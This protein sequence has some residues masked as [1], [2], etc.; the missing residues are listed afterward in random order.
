MALEGCPQKKAI[1]IW[2]RVY[3][4]KPKK[5]NSAIRK[6]AKCVFKSFTIKQVTVYIFSWTR[7]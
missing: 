2:L 3:T 7:A 5:P 1:R 6:V 4:K